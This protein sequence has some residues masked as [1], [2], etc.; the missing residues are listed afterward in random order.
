M[1]NAGYRIAEILHLVLLEGVQPVSIRAALVD[2]MDTA[3]T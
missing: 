2:E 3:L 1:M